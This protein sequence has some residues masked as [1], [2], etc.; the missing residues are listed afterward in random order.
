[1]KEKPLPKDNFLFPADNYE[2]FEKDLIIRI[3]RAQVK[4][5]IAVNQALICTGRL[6]AKS[7]LV[8]S[9]KAGKK[10]IDRHLRKIPPNSDGRT[11]G[12][13]KLRF[14]RIFEVK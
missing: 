7:L 4:A 5:A 9:R 13:Y 12:N 11:Q 6:G 1:M 2:V 8:S 14:K 10:V 3:R